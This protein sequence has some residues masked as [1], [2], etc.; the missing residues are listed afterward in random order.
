MRL[1]RTLGQ[2]EF[3]RELFALG[4]EPAAVLHGP[5]GGIEQVAGAAQQLAIL[6]GPVGLRRYPCRPEHF[7]QQAVAERLQQRDLVRRRLAARHHLGVLEHRMRAL[8]RTVHQVLVGPFE[9]E[10]DRQR[11]ANAPIPEL[12]PPGIEQPALRAGGPLVGNDLPLDAS[13]A[14]RGE[15]VAR[16]PDARGELFAEQ[17]VAA[18]EG[19]E[20][21]LAVTVVFVP[22]HIEIV[23]AAA[24][25][26]L[27]APPV[28]HALELD[29]TALLET[30]NAIGPG[31]QRR[32]QRGLV[33][34][35]R[36]IVLLGKDRH[37]RRERRHVEAAR[38]LEA[39]LDRPLVL[40]GGLG[41]IAEHGRVRRMPLALQRRQRK[42]HVGC[43][44]LAAVVE[45]NAR[46]QPETEH[47]PV[48][49]DGQ[50]IRRQEIDR[51]RL[52]ERPR[53]QRGESELHS[54]RPV[55][56]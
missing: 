48:G 30:R 1:E 51:V 47:Q 56:L 11:L 44:D 29:V 33:E 8:V 38:R 25:R 49:G 6:P 22:Q 12:V 50:F 21:G 43:G 13:V 55:A 19:L 37:R 54:V 2:Q 4:V 20:A 52:V 39:Q 17:I 32:F 34:R 16:R 45:G 23:Q 9:V 35:P 28:L 10:G 40:G 14:K 46:P 18:G 42:R 26:K 5:A 24:N 53:H 15:I 41:E 7:R 36:R 27:F 3:R 31:A